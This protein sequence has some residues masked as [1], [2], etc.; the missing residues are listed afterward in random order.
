MIPI[1]STQCLSQDLGFWNRFR[2]CYLSYVNSNTSLCFLNHLFSLF[3]LVPAYFFSSLYAGT[4]LHLV[5]LG[6]SLKN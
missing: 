4:T 3:L 2:S 6:S 5:T 1:P